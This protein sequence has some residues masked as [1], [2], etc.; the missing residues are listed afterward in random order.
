[1]SKLVRNWTGT[2]DGF[3]QEFAGPQSHTQPI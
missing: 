1:M 3:N 2:S